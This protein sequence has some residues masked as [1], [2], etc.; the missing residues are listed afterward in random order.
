MLCEVCG[1]CCLLTGQPLG[2]LLCCQRQ[3][4]VGLHLRDRGRLHTFWRVWRKKWR[5]EE[6]ARKKVD[7]G[8]RERERERERDREREEGRKLKNKTK[9]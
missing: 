9:S 2:Q 6:E 1:T 8:E 3:V 4:R 7:R 5:N